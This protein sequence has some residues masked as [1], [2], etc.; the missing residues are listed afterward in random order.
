MT[1]TRIPSQAACRHR[2]G[3]L[4]AALAVVVLAAGAAASA[5]TISVGELSAAIDPWTAAGMTPGEGGL[6]PDLWRGSDAGVIAPALQRLKAQP[7]S[8][9]AL[10]LARRTLL[11]GGG[12][13]ANA[14]PDLALLRVDRAAAF[15]TPEMIV[16]LA[17]RYPG[18]DRAPTVAIA[19]AEGLIAA[20]RQDAACTRAARFASGADA[21]SYFLKLRAYCFARAGDVA[22]ANLNLDIARAADGADAWFSQALGGRTGAYAG[23]PPAGRYRTALEA[24]ISS[25]A[26]LAPDMRALAAAPGLAL[27]ALATHPDTAP[28]LRIEAAQRAAALDVIGPAR[29]AE[30][31]T[32]GLAGLAGLTPAPVIPGPAASFAAVRDAPGAATATEADSKAALIAAALEAT[33]SYAGFAA[34]ARL[35][36]A[37]LQSIAPSEAL[38]AHARIFA[39]AALATYDPPGALAWRRVA[40]NL[41]PQIAAQIDL[42]VAALSGLTDDLAATALE[43]R[44][45]VAATPAQHRAAMRD[46]MLGLALGM[47]QTST[48]QRFMI[49]NEVAPGARVDLSLLANLVM[50][51][52]RAAVA[53]TALLAALMLQNG[54]V[55]RLDPIDAA[56]LIRA[57]REVDLE[58]DARQLA[59]EAMLAARHSQ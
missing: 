26:G 11:S 4:R 23:R 43:N 19:A 27:S 1:R 51:S 39:E 47:P 36:R 35:Y 10:S 59:I 50:T 30:A 38:S 54:G 32:A 52:R 22:A 9:T 18:I 44:L 12:A 41:D 53:E 45:A 58:D 16:A 15:A 25:Y 3:G 37:D 40:A 17:D 20:A 33:T 29:H 48:V 7:G 14:A 42:A 24:A 31:L 57:L 34:A 8:P 13:P 5:Q 6:R 49:Q 55:G 2:R 28:G 56:Q 46:V 21:A